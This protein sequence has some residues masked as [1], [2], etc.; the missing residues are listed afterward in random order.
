MAGKQLVK[1]TIEENESD[2]SAARR[3]L[4]E[5]SGIVTDISF[6]IV[7]LSRGIAPGQEWV[8]CEGFV[9]DMPE[10]WVFDTADNGGLRFH[11]FWQDIDTTLNDEWHLIFRAALNFYKST[12]CP[13]GKS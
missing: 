5:E 7:G 8:F 6:A 3:E 4:A 1:G 9:S 2:L 13:Y 12:K 11:F 10:S